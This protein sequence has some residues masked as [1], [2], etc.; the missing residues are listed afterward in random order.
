MRRGENRSTRRKTSR[1]REENQQ[2][3]QPTYD[4]ESGN[5]TRATLVESKCS[6][7]CAIPA[8]FLLC[9]RDF[10]DECCVIS[11]HC[12]WTL[13]VTDLGLVNMNPDFLATAYLLHES[14]FRPAKLLNLLTETASF[15][16]ALQSGSQGP[17][18]TNT[19]NKLCVFKNVRIRVGRALC[20]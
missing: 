19:V 17:A 10:S 18:L 11:R 16:T 9:L 4:V 20:S 3:T 8:P 13:L 14:T 5:R 6:H 12:P 15:E 7:H 1:S 2:Q